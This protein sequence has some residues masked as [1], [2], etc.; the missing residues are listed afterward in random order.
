MP[1]LNLVILYL[2]ICLLVLCGTPAAFPQDSKK[3][4]KKE[5]EEKAKDE[6][7]LEEL[8]PE[9]GLFG[10][11]ARSTSFSHD[12][13]HGAYLYRPYLERRHGSDLWLLDAES[14]EA[15]RVTRVSVMAR[16]QESTRKVQEDRRE[17]AKKR[18][19]K[20][21]KKK[22][23]EGQE[24]EEEDK[25][26]TRA[27][28]SENGDD[29]EGNDKDDEQKDEE[30]LG[31]TVGDKDADD[32]KAP[33]YGGI[34]SYTWS[35]TAEELLFT[36][37]GDIYQYTV[38]GDT[39]T[40]LTRT[41]ARERSVAY[42]PDGTGYTYM[43]GGALMKVTFDSHL[44][45]QL[46]PKL[47][48]G[49]TMSGYRLSPDGKRITFLTRKPIGP[50]PKRRSV[51]IVN[52]RDRFAQVRKVSREVSEDERREVELSVYLYEPESSMEEK[53]RLIK[54]YKVKQSAPRDLVSM[55]EWAP[56][57]SRVAFAAFDQPT[58]I[59]EILE[60]VFPEKPEEEKKAAETTEKEKAS[61]A[62]KKR[63]R[64]GTDKEDKE[65]KKKKKPGDARDK[66]KDDGSVDEKH[67][68]RVVY[69]F[70]HH[71]GPTTPWMVHP[72]YV[73]DSRRIAFISEQ[74]GFRHLHLLDPL[75]ETLDQ[76]TRGRF[77][78]YPV[79][80][81][82]DHRRIFFT[83]TKEG[84]SRRDVYRLDF[85]NGGM[86][87]LSREDGYY[88]G[89]AVSDD[90]R[91]VLANYVTFGKLREL[92]HSSG[93]DAPQ[94]TLTDS[95]PEKA[96]KLTG[97]I[98]TL[99]TFKNRH[100]QEINGQMFKPDGWTPEDKRP[101]LMYV[102]GGPL[103]ERKM[104]NDGSYS[105]D[106]YFFAYYM[107][108]KHG[109]VTCTIDPRGASGYGA[110]FEKANFERVGKPQVEDLVDGARWLVDNHGVDPERI[111]LHGWSFGGFQ[112]QM[113]LYTEPEFF[114]CGIAGAGPTE[115]ENYNSWYSTGTIGPSRKGK[116]DLSR[117]SLLPLAKNLEAKLLLVHGMEDSNVLYQDTVRVYRELLK[118]GKETLVELFLDPTGGHGLGGDIKRLGRFRKYEEFLLRV[119]GK[120][121]PAKGE[122]DAETE[123][124]EKAEIKV[125]EL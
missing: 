44:V 42:L 4:S 38:E 121:E 114:A 109:Y 97:P 81:S 68:A 20:Q 15:K 96:K 104:V 27:S 122:G 90:G 2:S 3:E 74:T 8:F 14:G 39:I 41:R 105:S 19:E 89:V 94:K 92:I 113:C 107:A 13:S 108:K 12:G 72:R 93:E 70:L 112:T 60:A 52:Y 34:S 75:Y 40:R 16:F 26:G 31:D 45:E 65:K 106:S 49:E 24:K 88:S 76:L 67:R 83:A 30:E 99:F 32:E 33:R 10:P 58:A 82:E 7:T 51:N 117:Y 120:G 100:G 84:P 98:P 21:E 48:K 78:V 125:E 77:E 124:E 110:L 69:R 115:W 66:D 79:S 91:K 37:G 25:G 59:V 111:A 18:K 50:E 118:A 116:P 101:L 123:P 63:K 22:E 95:H 35:P 1:R 28:S 5:A 85:E 103:G 56:D 86:E 17:K 23:E 29:D 6:L 57:S 47:S 73:H 64:D 87:R 9:K 54:V 61:K 46:D 11:S 71:G 62:N 55:P 102:Y 36:S 119:V 53:E 80:V 43:N